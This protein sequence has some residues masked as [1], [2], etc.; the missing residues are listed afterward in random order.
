[1]PVI[2]EN[3]GR[4]TQQKLRPW[5][6]LTG[7]S[8][9]SDFPLCLPLSVSRLTPFLFCA[10]YFCFSSAAVCGPL[11]MWGGVVYTKADRWFPYLV[12]T[13]Q[14][15]STGL[16]DHVVKSEVPWPPAN[17]RFTLHLLT[18]CYIWTQSRDESVSLLD[19]LLT[20]RVSQYS[21][22]HWVRERSPW[23]L[24]VSH[25]RTDCTRYHGIGCSLLTQFQR[26]KVWV[27]TEWAGHTGI[28]EILLAEGLGRRYIKRFR[29]LSEIAADLLKFFLRIFIF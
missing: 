28:T 5:P 10:A 3:L 2:S 19:P 18:A 16:H 4:I 8:P 9:F 29:F 17:A 6:S 7:L 27:Y 15:N 21:L 14:G 25:V 1:M 13:K 20:N 11:Q 24:A 12:R 23:P 22:F 26:Q